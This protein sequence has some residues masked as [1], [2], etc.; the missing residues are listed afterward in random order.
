[1]GWQTCNQMFLCSN[2]LFVAKVIGASACEEYSAIRLLRTLRHLLTN[3][4]QFD[5]LQS[6]PGRGP[7]A[8]RSIEAT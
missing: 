6:G 2:A 4:C 5:I 3:L 8:I 7:N 1:M